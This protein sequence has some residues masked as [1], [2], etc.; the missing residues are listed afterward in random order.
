MV[1]RLW[2]RGGISAEYGLSCLFH[3]VQGWEPH[4]VRYSSLAA[5]HYSPSVSGSPMY[6][7]FNLFKSLAFSL[8]Q[9]LNVLMYKIK[10]NMTAYSITLTFCIVT[11]YDA[12]SVTCYLP[13]LAFGL[14]LL[15]PQWDYQHNLIATM[16]PTFQICWDIFT[17]QTYLHSCV[18][19]CVCVWSG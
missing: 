2:F 19:V 15:D 7:M 13:I 18:C 6:L 17:W 16:F 3:V 8:W 12:F 10:F 5:P 14:C 4:Q 9:T 11:S 1:V